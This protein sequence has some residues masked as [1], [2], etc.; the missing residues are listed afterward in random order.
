MEHVKALLTSLSGTNTSL[1][2]P[3]VSDK[4]KKSF[5]FLISGMGGNQCYRCGKEDHWS[6]ECP[7]YP[8]TF[9]GSVFEQ[10]TRTEREGSVQLTSWY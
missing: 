3:I 5:I 7:T 2:Y 8:D 1:F 6:K 9:S 10:G 4:E